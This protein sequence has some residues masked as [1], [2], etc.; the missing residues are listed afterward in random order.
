[1][2]P[3]LSVYGH[4]TLDQILTVQRFPRDNTTED[5][6]AKS[7]S[8]GGTG[9]NIAVSAARLGCP[10]ALC[11]LIG[12][13]LPRHYRDLMADSGLILDE[14]VEVDG[15]ETSACVIAN[16]SC[17]TQKVLFYQGPQGFASEIG[18]RL[19][20]NASRSEHVH[21]CTG[22][23]EWYISI[24]R[25][26][27]G[28]SKTLDPAQESHRIWNADRLGRALPLADALFCN[29][30]E[31]ESLRTYIGADDILDADLPLVVCTEGAAGSRA[32]VGD[33]TIRIPAVR[34]ERAVDPTGCGDSYR[35]GF[36]AALYR[37]YG[38]PEALVVASSV[39]SFVLQE[40][41]ALSGTPAWEQ[42]IERAEP[43]FGEIHRRRRDAARTIVYH[44]AVRSG[45]PWSCTL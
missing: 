6:L 9:A 33:E 39:A 1:M 5:V 32:R 42:A 16:D 8:L 38:I 26:L 11:S 34:A 24:M 23:P 40:I 18:A 30:F 2:D 29:N 37:G 12:R 10:T 14:M 27:H 17:L 43:W 4:V 7:S 21:F 36:Y 31:A 44:Q 22:D 13:D 41:G 45:R 28:P 19:E 3:F 20:S 35:A 25:G 15:Y